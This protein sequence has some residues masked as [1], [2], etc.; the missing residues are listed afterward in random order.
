MGKTL[1]ELDNLL[2]QGNDRAIFDQ[3]EKFIAAVALAPQ[4]KQTATKAAIERIG[5]I[6]A[7]LAL[8]DEIAR[9]GNVALLGAPGKAQCRIEDVRISE[10][11]A[12]YSSRAADYVAVVRKARSEAETGIL[13]SAMALYL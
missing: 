6:D 9:A 3:K 11:L 5:K 12:D 2:R 1:G 4:E 13:G 7:T 10:R 8:T